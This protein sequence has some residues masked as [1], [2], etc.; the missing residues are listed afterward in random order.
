M[1]NQ[2]ATNT[3]F[4]KKAGGDTSA[5]FPLGHV[6]RPDGGP[7]SPGPRQARRP[8]T[9]AWPQRL[10]QRPQRGL[11]GQGGLA[12]VEGHDAAEMGKGRHP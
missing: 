2:W 11:F 8:H 7:D 9:A 10:Q 3:T 6:L 5:H 1:G 12:S 4:N